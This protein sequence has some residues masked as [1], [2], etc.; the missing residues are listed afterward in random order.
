MTQPPTE[1]PNLLAELT[2]PLWCGGPY[3]TGNMKAV[4]VAVHLTMHKKMYN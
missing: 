2:I 3:S 4:R 1:V